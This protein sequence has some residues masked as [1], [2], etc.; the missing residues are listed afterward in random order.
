MIAVVSHLCKYIHLAMSTPSRR[1]LFRAPPPRQIP[2]RARPLGWSESV[3]VPKRFRADDIKSALDTW[4][5]MDAE[6]IRH[7]CSRY[8]VPHVWGSLPMHASVPNDPRP[9]IPLGVDLSTIVGFIPVREAMENRMACIHDVANALIA[10]AETYIQEACI[11]RQLRQLRYTRKEVKVDM[12]KV[13]RDTFSEQHAQLLRRVNDATTVER[14]A[15]QTAVLA[16]RNV[17][18]SVHIPFGAPR[19]NLAGFSP[20]AEDD[21]E[22]RDEVVA[23]EEKSADHARNQRIRDLLDQTPLEVVGPEILSLSRVIRS[24]VRRFIRA[25]WLRFDAW[26]VESA[27]Q[28][29]LALRAAKDPPVVPPPSTSWMLGCFVVA[30]M[31]RAHHAAVAP[32][33]DV[34]TAY[35][36]LLFLANTGVDPGACGWMSRKDVAVKRAEALMFNARNQRIATGR[37][38]STLRKIT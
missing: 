19:F 32:M 25:E 34:G 13:V 3:P 18:G 37:V 35:D 14:N 2:T 31:L 24:I 20:L 38:R 21:D 23:P 4:W 16:C 1:P 6:W 15:Y 28:V 8:A 26:A 11:T 10:Q 22:D 36:R 27:Y 5:C 9:T 7:A 29:S 12:R 30:K 33:M 17:A